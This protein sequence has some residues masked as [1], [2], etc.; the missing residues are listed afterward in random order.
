[1]MLTAGTK[2]PAF[3]G[4]DADGNKLGLKNF[5]GKRLAIY[6]YPADDTPTCTKQACNLRDHYDT[7]LAAG[8]SILGISP[9]DTA[10]HK[11]FISKYA[12][13]FPLL[14]DKDA[15]IAQQFGVWGPKTFMG[16]NYVGLHRTTF[17]ID[18]KV[19]VWK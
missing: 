6:F 5:K 4:I 10:K 9:D 1:M 15:E 19:E 16:K 2:S 14:A 13:P 11:K 8:I 12:L 7:L 18:E 17:L 3:S